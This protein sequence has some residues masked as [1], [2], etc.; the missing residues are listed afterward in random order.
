MRDPDHLAWLANW[1]GLQC[2]GDWEH[3]D[4][5]RIETLDNP[6]W[7]VTV[8]LTGTELEARAFTATRSGET[9][10]DGDPKTRWYDCQVASGEFRGACGVFDL[11]RVLGIFR[12]WAESRPG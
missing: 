4:G 5:I 9:G 1:Y 12:D 6:G 10:G 11:G 8:S 7:M 3:Q 2:D